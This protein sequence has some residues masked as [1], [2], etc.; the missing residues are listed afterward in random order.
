M[1][2]SGETDGVQGSL[3]QGC[4]GLAPQHT[5]PVKEHQTKIQHKI[6]S[7]NPRV[8]REGRMR[9]PLSRTKR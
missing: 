2:T 4:E 5:V 9:D 6:K 8:F 7:N 3:K 1:V